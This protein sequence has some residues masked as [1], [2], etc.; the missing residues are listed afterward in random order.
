M[1]PD[2][3]ITVKFHDPN[4][5]SSVKN[6]MAKDPQFKTW[7]D[8]SQNSTDS[9]KIQQTTVDRLSAV[10]NSVQRFGLIIVL[11]F[12][13]ISILIVFNTIRMA[14]FSRR[15]EIDMMKAIGADQSFIRGPFL[16]EAEMYG[17]IA[18]VLALVI[19]YF[20]IGKIL[21]G[22]GSY[23]TTINTQ[24]IMGNWAWLVILAMVLVGVLIG[25]VSSRL[26]VRRYLKS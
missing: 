20:A 17:A 14:I 4:N 12:L 3:V 13:V 19:G 16:V 24:Q 26:A 10:M 5:T 23:F 6:L 1:N 11:L 7:L 21:P 2:A 8:N 15:E 22:L 18:A 25:G 9:T